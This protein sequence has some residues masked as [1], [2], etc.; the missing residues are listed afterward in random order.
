MNKRFTKICCLIIFSLF[1]LIGLV[2]CKPTE[3]SPPP[4]SPQP[5]TPPTPPPTPPPIVREI[6]N[7]IVIIGDGMGFEHIKAG[8][9]YEGKDY[10]FTNWHQ[11]SVNTDSINTSGALVLTDSAAGGTAIATGTL[12]HNGYV[13]VDTNNNSLETILDVANTSGKATGV[14]TTD[15]IYG[16]TPG[17]FSGHA[18]SRD[19]VGQIIETQFT[20][21][22]KAED[23]VP[24]LDVSLIPVKDKIN[25]FCA[26]KDK[27]SLTQE[28]E[29]R[30]LIQENGYTIC[31]DFA[32]VEST[33]D[34]EYAFWQ[35]DMYSYNREATVALESVTPYA[36]DY[37]D[38]DEDGFVVMI[39]QA[40]ID[41]YAHNK[42]ITGVLES[43]ISLNNTVEAVMEWIGDR[44]DTAVLITADHETGG[45]LIGAEENASSKT[46]ETLSGDDMLYY[47]S[48]GDHTQTLVGLFTYGITPNFV[49]FE[50]YSSNEKIKNIETN[51]I[52]RTLLANPK[53]Y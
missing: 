12:T 50:T 18:K 1:T 40:H 33:F 31:E 37:L 8:E 19:Y 42:N 9:L 5:P 23:A 4:L 20:G 3:S 35:F 47:F 2:G 30:S 48:S 11:T 21:R 29:Y 22:D 43:V 41:S 6:K 15:Y 7:I 10:S 36:L 53:A 49:E 32:D 44:T 25:L 52:I 34:S 14:I 28:Y 39:E 16:A 51:M 13:G 45:L 46:I 26:G 38:R 17:S 27:Y 24:E